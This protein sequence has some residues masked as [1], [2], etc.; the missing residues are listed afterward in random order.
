MSQFS[1]VRKFPT[2]H[3]RARPRPEKLI[4]GAKIDG[5]F[6]P[7]RPESLQGEKT[8]AS[9]CLKAATGRQHF[10]ESLIRQKNIHLLDF[11]AFMIGRYTSGSL[12]MRESVAC[13]HHA[14]VV[15]RGSAA[16]ISL[17]M[18]ASAGR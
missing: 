16:T 18:A 10:F 14:P 8:P 2:A 15:G 12:G 1:I 7:T 6:A 17:P 5:Y 13:L 3:R 4:R 9:C 11:F